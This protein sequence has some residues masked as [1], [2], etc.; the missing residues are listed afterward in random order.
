MVKPNALHTRLRLLLVLSALGPCSLP[1]QDAVAHTDPLDMSLEDLMKVEIDS[2][3]GASGYKQKVSEAPAS[4]T[5]ITA[6]DIRRY[7]YRTLAD[8]L[9]NV[10]GFYVTYDR[11]WTYIGVRGFSRP[12]D[13][14]SRVLLLVDGHRTN[15]SVYEEA[16]IGPE[17]PLDI[18]LIDRVEVIRGP[19]SSLYV[20][21]AF[22]AVINII[23]KPVN[24]Q[25]GLSAAGDMAS[26]GS[27]KSRLTYGH[28]FG[29]GLGVLVSGSYYDS[30]GQNLFFP[31]F[32]SPATNYGWADN[33]DHEESHQFFADLTYGGFRLEGVYGAREK[34][35][36]TASFG[37]AFDDSRARSTGARS[38]VDLTYDHQF[39]SDWG[40]T[41]RVFYDDIWYNGFYPALTGA[42][43]P[44]V[45]NNDRSSG[46]WWG[47]QAALSKQLSHNQTLVLGAEYRDNFEQYL[48]NFNE[49]PYW[50]YFT[51]KQ[52]SDVMAAYVQD[53][54]V[55]NSKVTLD[56][57][58]RGDHY[59]TFGGST[60]PRA[61][62]IY[63]PGS[64]TAVKLLYGHAFRA[65][66]DFELYYAGYLQEGNPKLRPETVKTTEAV[67]EQGF[68]GGM[69]ISVSGY[70]YPIRDL[71]SQSMDPATGNM[72]YVNAGRVY[73]RGVEASFDKHWRSGLEA[74]ASLS[75]Q[76]ATQSDSPMPL[77]DSPRWL[78]QGKLSLPVFKGQLL[79]SLDFSYVSRRLTWAGD[80][81]AGYFLPD[82]T[83]LSN[84][85][86]RW[87]I[88][89]SLYNALNRRYTDPGSIGDP[90]DVI[91]Q[92]GRNFRVKCTYRF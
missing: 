62:L 90:E 86:K 25:N 37:D 72:V 79:A 10:P 20:P 41:S 2:V 63:K 28:Q 32:D 75:A 80:Y 33:A 81:A 47:A 11:N 77:T 7:G 67:L 4:I 31:R 39:G 83:L 3:Y 46:K 56:L 61:G 40:F 15:D 38:Y 60:N 65:P 82:I 13:Y 66:N 52:K 76:H 29:D 48:T 19:N 78:S 22:L 21:S 6:E 85:S 12:G 43:P 5:I 18:D 88:S 27:Y 16:L 73:L 53:E 57:G 91:V 45:L 24:R 55:V 9:R 59:S 74:G 8:V 42:D 23:T 87:E 14:N 70:Y 69:R 17:F 26:Y 36:P 30:R 50:L 35:I 51:S 89:A 1:A 44:T 71:I 34:N 49:Q 64:H 92:N 68:G 58:L 84:H 54:I